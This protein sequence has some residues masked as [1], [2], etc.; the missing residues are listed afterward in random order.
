MSLLNNV[1]HFAVKLQCLTA[2]RTAGLAVLAVL[3][4]LARGA[5]AVRTAS[6]T[7]GHFITIPRVEIF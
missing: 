7:L 2:R 4:V 1:S 6:G 3:T 5:L